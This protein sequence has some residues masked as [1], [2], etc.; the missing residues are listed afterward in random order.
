[1]LAK[2][3][4]DLIPKETLDYKV[5]EAIGL[6]KLSM[7]M[8]PEDAI[9]LAMKKEEVAMK[10]YTHLADVSADESLKELFTNLASME[11]EHKFK[12]EKVFVEREYPEIW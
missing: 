2:G 6:P 3:T 5:S 7:D 11:R 9:G 1:M 4:F 12:L 10:H 8:K